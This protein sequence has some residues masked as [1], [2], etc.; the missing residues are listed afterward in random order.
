MFRTSGCYKCPNGTARSAHNQPQGNSPNS[1]SSESTVETNIMTNEWQSIPSL[2][3]DSSEG[4]FT[5]SDSES[6]ATHIYKSRSITPRPADT[7]FSF[8]YVFQL[9]KFATINR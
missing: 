7:K 9:Q 6:L 2:D 3:H 1:E 8:C 4:H 5:R